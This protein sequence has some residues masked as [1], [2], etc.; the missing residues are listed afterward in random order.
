MPESYEI[1]ADR[2]LVVCRA[3]GS[4][5]NED[6]R[7]HYRRLVADP[8][9]RPEYS[10]IA[11]LR[12][13]TDFAVDSATIESVAQRPVFA[14]GTRRAFIAPKGIAFGLVR[15]FATHSLAID[16]VLEIFSDERLARE[17]LGV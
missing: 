12:D 2:E 16:Q 10:Q 9:F 5:S 11:D 13:V 14:P 17:W 7:E 1:D 6:L 15:M 3:W 8:D 4:L